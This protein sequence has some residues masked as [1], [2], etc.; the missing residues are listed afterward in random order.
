MRQTHANTPRQMTQTSTAPATSI[1]IA[2]RDTASRRKKSA[3]ATAKWRMD[4]DTR[5]RSCC[6]TVVTVPGGGIM[7]STR[8]EPAALPTTGLLR[9]TPPSEPEKCAVPYVKTPPSEAASQY[10]APPATAA[11]PTTGRLSGRLPAE[12]KNP[13]SPKLKMPPSDATIQ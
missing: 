3:T 8:K 9:T 1:P 10:P 2:V 4:G 11:M 12:P 13:A 6:S 5:Q 7:A